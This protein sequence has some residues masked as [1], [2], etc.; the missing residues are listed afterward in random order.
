MI[1]LEFYSPTLMLSQFNFTIFVNGLVVQISQLCAGVMSF[2]MISRLKRR[3]VAI[4]GLVILGICSVV[5][6]FIWDQDK[7]KVD[8][9]WT[10]V[11][12][13]IMLFIFQMT[14]SI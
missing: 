10:N 12:V 4:V 8:N 14:T 3:N 9:I 13:L 5:M 6:I 1:V 11:G 7:E 2:I